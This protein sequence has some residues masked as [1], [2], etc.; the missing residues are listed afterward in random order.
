MPRRDRPPTNLGFALLGLVQDQPRSGYA[1]RKAFETT[2]IGRYS[3]SPGSIYPALKNLM[4]AGLLEQRSA[5]NGKEIFHITAKGRRTVRAW[6]L[7]PV[8]VDEV[9][10]DMD[11]VMLRFAFMEWLN[12]DRATVGFLHSFEDAVTRHLAVLQSFVK[13]EAASR[14]TRH[15]ALAVQAGIAGYEGQLNWIQRALRVFSKGDGS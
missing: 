11:T 1:L 12:D 13:S 6:H 14:L 15:G 5:E 8:T 7:K 2:P 3:D 4:R 10:R 9:A